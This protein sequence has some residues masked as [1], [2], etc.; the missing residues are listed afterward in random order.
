MLYEIGFM[1]LLCTYRASDDPELLGH[2]PREEPLSRVTATAT[3]RSRD[4][5]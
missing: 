1:M 2:R 4:I 5:W 3:A